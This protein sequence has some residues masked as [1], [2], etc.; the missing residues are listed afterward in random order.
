MG[1]TVIWGATFLVVHLAMQTSG[2]FFFVGI[3]FLIAGAVSWLVF[4]PRLQGLTRV[5]AVAG[6]SI[7][8]TLTLG[9]GLQTLG[10]V[11][12][13]SSVSAF[14]TTFYVPLMPL[15]QWLVLRMPPQPMTWLGIALAFVGLVF[16]A[17]PTSA[18]FTL[19]AGQL[20]TLLATVAFAAQIILISYFAPHVD[21][22][23]VTV[24]ELVVGGVGSF[25]LMS[26]TGEQI[27]QYHWGWVAAALGLGVATTV[28]Q[29]VM[30]WAQTT[31][32]PTRAT[33]IYTG[34]PVWAAL[35]GWLAGER[36]PWSAFVGGALIVAGIL[37]S[38]LPTPRRWRAPSGPPLAR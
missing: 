14:F 28:I 19:G 20:V 10:L 15:L 32:S 12:I 37:L 18:G 16:L 26:L 38:E 35:I 31:V 1:V 13:D 6:A 27:P 9:Y 2:P 8:L 23:R 29:S 24:V 21:V 7:G 5:E 22:G 30:N 34:E 25:L 36:L 4:R 17:G 33:I 11:T 3:R